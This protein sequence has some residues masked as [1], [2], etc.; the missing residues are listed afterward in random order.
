MDLKATLKQL[1]QLLSILIAVC[2]VALVLGELWPR[3]EQPL[4]AWP[5]LLAV[6]GLVALPFL[7]A[8]GVAALYPQAERLRYK[9]DTPRVDELPDARAR[10]GGRQWEQ[11]IKV[12]QETWH[13]E[14]TRFEHS[15]DRIV[16][17]ALLFGVVG[18]VLLAT[19]VLVAAWS[20]QRRF[21][22]VGLQVVTTLA[23]S[24][25]VATSAAYALNLARL[26][27]RTASHDYNARMFSWAT[28]SVVLTVV[29][30]IGL[31]VLMLK[32]GGQASTTTLGGAVLLGL[33]A[34]ALGDHAMELLIEKASVVFGAAAPARTESTLKQLDGMTDADAERFEEEGILSLH[35]L[36]FAPT[37]RLF[38][39]TTYSLQRLCDWQDQA[40][41]RAY[42]GPQR[43][44]QLFGKLAIRGAIDLQG[45]AEDLEASPA[46]AARAPGGG[47]GAKAGHPA[48]L[49]ETAR[50]ALLVESDEALQQALSTVLRDE[51]TMRLRVH[52]RSAPHE[53][54]RDEPVASADGE[55]AGELERAAPRGQAH[56]PHRAVHP[57]H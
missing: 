50:A 4:L 31:W 51:V 49:A 37:A 38:F 39:N 1:P 8:L 28:R 48:T 15:L 12:V 7:L 6:A 55:V 56:A 16:P 17:N 25:A 47:A 23:L 44:A 41:L 2:C 30:D 13:Y 3:G 20:W 53:P 5:Q 52:F 33:F 36:A 9:L 26:L 40:L 10:H 14:K 11:V 21:V 57:H 35:D 34:A 46:T 27:V 43:S 19:A 22:P 45:L 29:A 54:K 24:V 18:T 32:V 42:M